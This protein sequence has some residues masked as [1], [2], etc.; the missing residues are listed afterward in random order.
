MFCPKCGRQQPTNTRFC[1][2]C[3]FQLDGTSQL[4]ANDGMLPMINNMPP[5][6]SAFPEKKAKPRG[7]KIG[8]ILML[9]SAVLSP[10]FFGA[11]IAADHPGPLIVPFTMFLA[12]FATLIYSLIFRDSTPQVTHPQSFHP[13]QPIQPIH[14]SPP[15]GLPQPHVHRVEN[16]QKPL[17]T[18]EIVNTPSVTEGTTQLFD[19]EKQ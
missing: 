3:G 7:M 5:Q 12:G 11:S 15:P 16:F 4:L 8:V 9:I 14:P 13:R 1:S 17:N 2:G 6:T 18:S 19:K 10:I